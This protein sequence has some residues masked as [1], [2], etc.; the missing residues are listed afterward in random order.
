M[1]TERKKHWD[2]NKTSDHL[3]AYLHLVIS[4]V[5]QVLS[6]LRLPV[7]RSEQERSS[8][9]PMLWLVNTRARRASWYVPPTCSSALWWTWR[10]VPC[11]T[12]SMKARP[13]TKP[14]WTSTWITWASNPVLSSS[15]LS[16]STTL[17]TAAA[18][19]TPLC[20]RAC[21]TTSSWCSSFQ[22]CRR[23]QVTLARRGPPTC[24]RKSSLTVALFRLWGLMLEGDT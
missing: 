5:L 22:L 16:P 15:S 14:L 12:R 23:G 4:S 11:S 9:A 20:V 21:Q 2:I 1:K 18:H 8:S 17:W 7:P 3:T 24:A 19:C 10:W 6:W 13:C